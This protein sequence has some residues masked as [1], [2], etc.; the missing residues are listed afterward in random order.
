MSETSET[1]VRVRIADD[2]DACQVLVDAIFAEAR[3]AFAQ[4]VDGLLEL[5]NGAMALRDEDDRARALQAVRVFVLDKFA[6]RLR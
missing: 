6:Q 5:L 1:Q 2:A 3:Q 4:D